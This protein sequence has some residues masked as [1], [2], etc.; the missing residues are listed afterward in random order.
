M[1]PFYTAGLSLRADERSS[2]AT[3]SRRATEIVHAFITRHS[4]PIRSQYSQKIPRMSS[5][6]FENW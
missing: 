1:G 2:F 3:D 4:T 6:R 5:E